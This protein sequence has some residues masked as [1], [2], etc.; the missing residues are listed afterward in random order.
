VKGQN[1]FSPAV[2]VQQDG[3][4]QTLKQSPKV[5]T[6]NGAKNNHKISNQDK[7]TVNYSRKTNCVRKEKEKTL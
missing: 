1:L 4:M 6:N 5:Q 2:R 7:Q 3:F